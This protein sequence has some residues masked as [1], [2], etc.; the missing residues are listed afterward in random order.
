MRS[1]YFTAPYYLSS[2]SKLVARVLVT[3]VLFMAAGCRVEGDF[4]LSFK[5][6][7]Q[8]HSIQNIFL[9]LKFFHLLNLQDLKHEPAIVFRKDQL[10]RFGS[11]CCFFHLSVIEELLNSVESCF[12]KFIGQKLLGSL[13]HLVLGDYRLSSASRIPQAGPM[14]ERQKS[15]YYFPFTFRKER[16]SFLFL[17]SKALKIS[18]LFQNISSMYN[19]K[20]QSLMN[21][22]V[23][24]NYQLMANLISFIPPSILSFLPLWVILKQ[25]QDIISFY[26]YSLQFVLLKDK[27]SFR[28]NHNTINP[29]KNGQ[30][31]FNIIKY[32]V[33]F[34]FVQLLLAND[35][36]Q[37]VC[38]IKD[39]KKVHTLDFVISLLKSVSFLL[40]PFL[41]TFYLLKNLGL[42]SV[43]C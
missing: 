22:H 35:L 13:E 27:H 12:I 25:I 19:G 3:T 10:L 15:A 14:K 16:S 37:L 2:C 31:C 28:H 40:S 5:K 6:P 32:P 36:L 17:Q 39:P 26:P 23:P 24:T 4:T 41:L 42:L 34:Q 18:C 29:C 9:R 7:S 8:R 33:N 1:F 11:C 30:F 20:E 38:L 43:F 21:P